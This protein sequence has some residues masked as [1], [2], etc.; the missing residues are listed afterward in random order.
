M[1]DPANASQPARPTHAGHR[2]RL[3]HRFL[4]AG[5]DAVADYELIELAL[6]AAKPRGD[7]KP[8]AKALLDRFGSFEEVVSAP[9]ASL[10]Q[11]QGVGDAAVAALKLIETAAI[12]LARGRI[13]DQPVIGSW[14][15]LLAYCR[16]KLS[17]LGHEEFHVLFLD[18]KNRLIADELQGR[19]TIDHTPVYPREVV[20]RALEHGAAAIILVHNH[21]SGDPEPSSA[22][23]EMTREVAKSATALGVTLHDHLIIG[24]REHVSLRARGILN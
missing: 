16:S 4:S 24:A 5:G 8:L 6:F 23:V 11:T 20:K 15:A 12:R 17:F 18:R 9:A 13:V 3:R 2:E 22:D 14:D 1:G 21:P 7:T 19:G 10:R